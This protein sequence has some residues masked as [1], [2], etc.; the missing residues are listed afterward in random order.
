MTSRQVFLLVLACAGAGAVGGTVY[1]SKTRGARTPIPPPASVIPSTPESQDDPRN[2]KILKREFTDAEKSSLG[3]MQTRIGE[4]RDEIDRLGTRIVQVKYSKAQVDPEVVRLERAIKEDTE[5]LNQAW[6]AIPEHV[7]ARK[8]CDELMA[9][10][11]DLM[12]RLRQLEGHLEQH[13]KASP[14]GRPARPYIRCPHCQAD[15]EKFAA[16][17]PELLKQ[18]EQ[19]LKD[20]TAETARTQGEFQAASLAMARV[21]AEGR[22][23]PQILALAERLSAARAAIDER[24]NEMI[25]VKEL[26]AERDRLQKGMERLIERRSNL[27]KKAKLVEED[28]VPKGVAVDGGQP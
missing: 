27:V 2:P 28:A 24:L 3:E 25:E 6:A 26:T 20:M 13:G 16:G 19:Q 12:N 10:R 23:Q 17:D 18:L 4:L 8:K 21:L 5:A 14:D 11:Q 22:K 7:E 9:R 1:W 15:F